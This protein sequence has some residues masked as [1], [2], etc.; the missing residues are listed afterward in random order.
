MISQD[1]LERRR[2]F[3]RAHRISKDFKILQDVL[4]SCRIS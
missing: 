4:K 2:I 3:L 1:V